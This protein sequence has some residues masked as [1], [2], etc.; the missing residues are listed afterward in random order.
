VRTLLSQYKKQGDYIISWG[1][2]NDN[3]VSVASGI[4]YYSLKIG[5]QFENKKMIRIK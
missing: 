5:E 1:G 2:K 3:G 4:Y